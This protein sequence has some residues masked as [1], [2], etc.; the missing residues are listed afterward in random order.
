MSN[1]SN[2]FHSLI[3][4]NVL[5][6]KSSNFIGLFSLD[7]GDPLLHQISTFH[8]QKQ[9]PIISLNFAGRNDLSKWI[10]EESFMGDQI[11]KTDSVL[12][13]CEDMLRSFTRI[14]LAAYLKL[15]IIQFIKILR[16]KCKMY[17][18]QKSLIRRVAR[19][20]GSPRLGP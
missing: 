17:S 16:L 14:A 1:W 4:S 2:S 12:V 5:L 18:P 8:V 9:S 6:D 11:K 20:R 3:N 13:E 15:K 19:P 10:M 7:P